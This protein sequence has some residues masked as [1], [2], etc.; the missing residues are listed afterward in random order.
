VRFLAVL[1]GVLA[2]AATNS[3]GWQ[4]F[5]TNGA[6]VRYPPSWHATTR[7]L[8]SVTSPSELVAVA[9]FAF[10][11]RIVSDGCQPT[12]TLA[13]MQPAGALIYAIEYASVVRKTDFPPRPKR[14]RLARF[15]NYECFGRSYLLRF[16][17]RG[18]YFQLQVAFG[19]R[20]TATTRA[21][22]LQVI[23]TFHAR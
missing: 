6:E 1:I 23:N 10:P 14:L 21:T 16:Q 12:G 13:K 18:R 4:A 7:P 22:T 20:A 17:E 15:W 19:R 5:H 11:K 2:I 8:T 9:S 3:P